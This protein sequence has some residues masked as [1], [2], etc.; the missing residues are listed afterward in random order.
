MKD[1]RQARTFDA[2]VRA[3]QDLLES[4]GYDAVQPRVVAK[5][6]R[7]SLTTIYKL[8][9]TRDDL[10]VAALERWMDAHS[11]SR[12]VDPPAHASPREGL[13]WVYRQLFEPWQDSP[14]MLEAYYRARTGPG[15]EKLD[16]QSAQAVEPLAS[17]FLGKLDPAYATDVGLIMTNMVCGVIQ[18]CAVGEIPA[19]DILPMLERTLFRLTTNNEPLATGAAP[20]ARR[21][22]KRKP[23]RKPR[24]TRNAR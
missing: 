3:V 24:A 9:P 21:P 23:V 5:R 19:T 1:D 20:R 7:V 18:R 13:M 10:I 8:A 12:M 17:A 2:I 11:I 15:G 16:A 22:R 14:R 4:E 6:A